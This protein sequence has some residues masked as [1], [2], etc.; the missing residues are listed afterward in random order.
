MTWHKTI[1]ENCPNA[2]RTG[3]YSNWHYCINPENHR[4]LENMRIIRTACDMT[5]EKYDIDGPHWCPNKAE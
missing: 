2:D 1:C 5:G 4:G 3:R